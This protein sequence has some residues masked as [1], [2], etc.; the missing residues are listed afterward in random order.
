[1]SDEDVA[2]DREV[3]AMTVS[4]SGAVR[5]RAITAGVIWT[6]IPEGQTPSPGAA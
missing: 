2:A 5:S 3:R 4:R 6:V 1:V